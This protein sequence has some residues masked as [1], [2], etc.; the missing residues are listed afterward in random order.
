MGDPQSINLGLILVQMDAISGT[1]E[2]SAS[3][4]NHNSVFR[5]ESCRPTSSGTPHLTMWMPGGSPPSLK[6]RCCRLTAPP[7]FCVVAAPTP[8][9]PRTC[10]KCTCPIVNLWAAYATSLAIYWNVMLLVFLAKP[11]QMLLVHIRQRPPSIE[12]LSGI[13]HAV[14]LLDGHWQVLGPVLL[15]VGTQQMRWHF[16]RHNGLI[17]NA[18]ELS[19][20]RICSFDRLL[21]IAVNRS[22]N[23]DEP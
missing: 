21:H 8:M 1:S 10:A 6:N 4:C 11:L 14:G 2:N 18:L 3:F 20:A 15:R 12:F 16:A 13:H 23:G 17:R 5:S 22:K 19:T 9:E 7:S